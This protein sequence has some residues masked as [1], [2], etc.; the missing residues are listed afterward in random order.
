M[1][2]KLKIIQDNIRKLQDPDALGE[3]ILFI[4][5]DLYWLS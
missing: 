4:F 5:I 3:I 1:E 2:K